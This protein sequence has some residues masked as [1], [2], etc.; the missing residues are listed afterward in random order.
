MLPKIVIRLMTASI[1]LLNIQGIDASCRDWIVEGCD[2][3]TPDQ[4]V[5]GNF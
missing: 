4:T 1:G 3:P 5:K 2:L